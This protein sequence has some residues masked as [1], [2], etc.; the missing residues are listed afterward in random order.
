[1][2]IIE[3]AKLLKENTE[4]CMGYTGVRK[5]LELTEYM[6]GCGKLNDISYLSCSVGI[7]KFN[8]SS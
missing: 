2:A 6:L 1:M 8:C 7:V 5:T 4:E 3:N